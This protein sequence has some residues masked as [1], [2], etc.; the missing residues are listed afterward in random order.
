MVTNTPGIHGLLLQLIL[1]V[2]ATP[3]MLSILVLCYGKL[4]HAALFQSSGRV[5]SQAL[6]FKI[7]ENHVNVSKL[8]LIFL[9][10]GARA[11][12]VL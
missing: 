9:N 8:S 4:Q 10:E 2:Q 5:Q 6:F 7:P 3:L 11:R 1:E 12:S